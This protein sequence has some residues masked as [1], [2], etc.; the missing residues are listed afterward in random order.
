MEEEEQSSSTPAPVYEDQ[1]NHPT[2]T[3]D[4]DLHTLFGIRPLQVS[5]PYV[6]G[7]RP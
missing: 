4:E 3:D 7:I 6:D 1:V 2:S 5:T